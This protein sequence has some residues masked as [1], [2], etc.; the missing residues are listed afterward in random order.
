[1]KEKLHRHS[2]KT[3]IFANCNSLC[4]YAHCILSR[5][6][7]PL[8]FRSYLAYIDILSYIFHFVNT[9]FRFYTFSLSFLNKNRSKVRHY[10]NNHSFQGVTQSIISIVYYTL[11]F[12]KQIM[13]CALSVSAAKQKRI[14]KDANQ[15]CFTGSDLCLTAQ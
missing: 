15:A 9:K 11:L 13:F 7:L 12:S 14:K 6:C 2:A 1:M 3:H 4:E 8:M 5:P 10:N